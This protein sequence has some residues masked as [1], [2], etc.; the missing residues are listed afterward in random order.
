M[1]RCRGGDWSS[2]R[3]DF[4]IEKVGIM[5]VM[6]LAQLASDEVLEAAYEW[7][8]RRRRDYPERRRVGVPLLLGAG[9]ELDQEMNFG[10]AAIA[11]RFSPG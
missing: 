9:K 8:C 7:L 4:R 3:A 1:G 10:R 2:I 5:S 11:F 6:I